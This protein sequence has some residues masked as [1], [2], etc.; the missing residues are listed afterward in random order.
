MAN[1][2]SGEFGA[3][4]TVEY[5]MLEYFAVTA[6]D[7]TTWTYAPR[8]SATET[9]GRGRAIL[10]GATFHLPASPS[11]AF[12]V[13]ALPVEAGSNAEL[14]REVYGSWELEFAY[15]VRMPPGPLAVDLTFQD[16]AGRMRRMTVAGSVVPGAPPETYSGGYGAYTFSPTAVCY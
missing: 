3:A 12:C 15:G 11:W 4:L 16:D 14:I 6:G 10:A 2:A 5:R 8:I 1:E 13:S 9:T 7:D